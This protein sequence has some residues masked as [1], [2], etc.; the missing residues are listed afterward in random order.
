MGET[1]KKYDN[2]CQQQQN[3]KKK[4]DIT[5][6]FVEVGHLHYSWSIL[7][8]STDEYRISLILMPT[9]DSNFINTNIISR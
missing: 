9:A 8:S 4:S 5:A 7:I 1:L 3:W 2:T 6:D